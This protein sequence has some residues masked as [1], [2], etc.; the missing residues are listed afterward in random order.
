MQENFDLARVI[1]RLDISRIR[2][3]GKPKT[4]LKPAKIDNL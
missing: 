3:I 1:K 4:S 2:P